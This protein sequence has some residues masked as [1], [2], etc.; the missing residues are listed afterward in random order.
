MENQATATV[1]NPYG[2]GALWAGGD[3]IARSVLILLAIMS[4][5]TFTLSPGFREPIVV[6]LSVCGINAQLKRRPRIENTVSEIPS[7]ATEPF[8]TR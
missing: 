3:L 6:T 7:I 5:S 1:D 8:S 2:L 4:L